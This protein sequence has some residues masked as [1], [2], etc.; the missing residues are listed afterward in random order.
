MK[1]HNAQGKSVLS[2]LTFDCAKIA[3]KQNTQREKMRVVCTQTH[4]HAHIRGMSAYLAYS[5][6]FQHFNNSMPY[7]HVVRIC[8]SQG[9]S[10]EKENKQQKIVV[11]LASVFLPT[12]FLAYLFVFV[13]FGSSNKKEEYEIWAQSNAP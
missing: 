1:N 13:K 9:Y 8:C 2:L 3:G 5:S 11:F 7:P 6:S 10:H 12:F 4:T